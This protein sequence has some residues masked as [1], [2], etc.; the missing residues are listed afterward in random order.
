MKEDII[1][2][3]GTYYIIVNK[4]EVPF[5]NELENTNKGII[6]E[7]GTFKI[8]KAPS[9]EIMAKIDR[10]LTDDFRNKHNNFT[11]KENINKKE[12]Y[13][14]KK[15]NKNYIYDNGCYLNIYNSND[16]YNFAIYNENKDCLTAGV[17]PFC[18]SFDEK[19][20]ISDIAEFT[21]YDF[22]YSNKHEIDSIDFDNIKI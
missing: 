16:G 12:F 8:Y 3:I 21:C 13:T 9:L 1:L 11:L 10:L 19:E 7:L 17:I 22:L 6:N 2:N 14:A 20:I 4:E 18:N 5:F 15:I